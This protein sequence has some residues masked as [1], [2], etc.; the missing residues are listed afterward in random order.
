MQLSWAE[1]RLWVTDY[2]LQALTV[3]NSTADRYLLFTIHSEL[4]QLAP[5]YPNVAGWTKIQPGEY[6]CGR[7]VIAFA[8]DSGAITS[9]FDTKTESQVCP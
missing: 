3:G 7:F 8:P 5:A 9:L 6:N 4:A 2:P 1:Q